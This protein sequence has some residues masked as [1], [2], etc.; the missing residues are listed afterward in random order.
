MPTIKLSATAIRGLSLPTSRL[1]YWDASLTGF[2]VKVEPTGCKTYLVKFRDEY[3]RQK[4]ITLGTVNVIPHDQA[5][6]AAQKLL[7]SVRLGIAIGQP[8][9]SR[10]L[11]TIDTIYESYMEEHMKGKSTEPN[12]RS[13]YTNYIKPRFGKKDYREVTRKAVKK[14]HEEITANNSN[15]QADNSVKYLGAM[16]N[17]AIPDII[18]ETTPNPCLKIGFHGNETRDRILT[19][20]EY[21]KLFAAIATA[22]KTPK[23]YRP[24]IW[25][26]E[27]LIFTGLRKNEVLEMKKEHIDREAG[28][29]KVKDKGLNKDGTQRS[30][31]IPITPAVED[32][33]N[34]MEDQPLSPWV[35][36]S[37][38]GAKKHKHL[39]SIDEPWFAVRSAA[40]L[41]GDDRVWIHDLRRSWISFGTNDANL[42]VE[43][44]SKAV[45]HSTVELTKRHYDRQA[46]KN[47]MDVSTAIS[48]G[49]AALR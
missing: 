29:I 8:R 7:A 24:S 3:R 5:R 43:Q 28:V 33:L 18:P 47:K 16:F 11:I 31:T 19:E 15:S 48:D 2:G 23:V 49:I 14:M 1:I 45:G 40:G 27:M 20:E 34:R 4:V 22:L 17:W 9:E 46:A 35:F 44:V 36:P 12:V 38:H 21:T 30:K 10:K 37:S 6:E 41:G 26:I 42:N 13:I 32:L 25:A 39:S